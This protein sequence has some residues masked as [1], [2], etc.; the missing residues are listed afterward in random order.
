MLRTLSRAGHTFV[1]TQS[2]NP[3]ALPA[4]ELAGRAEPFF[5]RVETVSD[6]VAARERALGGGGSVLVTGSLY[7]LADLYARLEGLR[8]A[9]VHG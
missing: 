8:C 7:L 3:R 9:T 5:E 6:P 4:A 2:S 1:A